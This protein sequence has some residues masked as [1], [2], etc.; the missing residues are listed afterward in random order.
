MTLSYNFFAILKYIFRR[1]ELVNVT[2]HVFFTKRA[3]NKKKQFS[4]KR[5]RTVY[6]SLDKSKHTFSNLI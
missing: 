1:T 2:V 6:K 5:Q 4:K 3:C